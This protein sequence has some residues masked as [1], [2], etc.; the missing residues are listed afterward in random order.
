MKNK[1]KKKKIKKKIKVF[2]K[3]LKFAYETNIHRRMRTTNNSVFVLKLI[4][5]RITNQFRFARLRIGGKLNTYNI[6]IFFLLSFVWKLFSCHIQ[7]S[8]VPSNKKKISFSVHAL[9]SV[10]WV[11]VYEFNGKRKTFFSTIFEIFL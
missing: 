9:T 8:S 7:F 11:N 10:N 6:F 4:S 3:V 2:T 1:R 5:S